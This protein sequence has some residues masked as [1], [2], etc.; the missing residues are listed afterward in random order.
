[1]EGY[2]NQVVVAKP[3]YEPGRTKNLLHHTIMLSLNPKT[4]R[5]DAI[6]QRIPADA[7]TR[8]QDRWHFSNRFCAYAWGMRSNGTESPVN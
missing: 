3:V 5:N 7:A 1:M 4:R 6:Q 2:C 8:R